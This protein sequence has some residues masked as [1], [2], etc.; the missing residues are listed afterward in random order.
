MLG[1][2]AAVGF[3]DVLRSTNDIVEVTESLTAVTAGLGTAFET[4]LRR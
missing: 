1:L 2:S 4:T 3:G